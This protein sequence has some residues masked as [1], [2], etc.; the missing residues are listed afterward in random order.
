M[1]GWGGGGGG[2]REQSRLGMVPMSFC[3]ASGF[4]WCSEQGKGQTWVHGVWN[5]ADGFNAF[6]ASCLAM[7]NACKGSML[8]HGAPK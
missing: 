2:N 4:F 1:Y 3:C 6:V 7:K 8:V 5:H